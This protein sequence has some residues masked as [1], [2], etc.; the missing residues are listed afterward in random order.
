MGGSL[1]AETNGRAVLRA[2]PWSMSG[3][4]LGRVRRWF[5][6]RPRWRDLAALAGIGWRTLALVPA[7]LRGMWKPWGLLDSAHEFRGI[8]SFQVAETPERTSELELV[9]ARLASGRV[10]ARWRRGDA[11]DAPGIL[12]LRGGRPVAW[13]YSRRL[14]TR[15][16]NGV[17]VRSELD[18][19]GAEWDEAWVLRDHE[20]VARLPR[21]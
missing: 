7:L 2:L 6:E 18:V 14:R 13:P 5:P 21:R 15:R 10:I 20:R 8:G 3:G 9:D 11:A 16:E 12:L 1:L 17:P 4:L 19:R